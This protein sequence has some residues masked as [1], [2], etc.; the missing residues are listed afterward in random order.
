MATKGQIA[1]GS[2]PAGGKAIRIVVSISVA[3]GVLLAFSPGVSAAAENCHVE[4]A[5]LK[6]MTTQ[7]LTQRYCISGGMA[8]SATQGA[9]QVTIAGS[10]KLAQQ[11]HDTA[12]QCMKLRGTISELLKQRSANPDP[13][14]MPAKALRERR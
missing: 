1:A 4:S 8:D 14:C 12:I 9:N 5:E 13:P 10:P 7:V 2:D 3:F 11:F 6:G